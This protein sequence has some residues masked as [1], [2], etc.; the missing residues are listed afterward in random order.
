MSGSPWP[1]ARTPSII[2]GSPRAATAW[3]ASSPPPRLGS[4]PCRSFPARLIAAAALRLA[5]P[6]PSISDSPRRRDGISAR[7]TISEHFRLASSPRRHLGSY[8]HLRAM[9][10]HASS[11]RR[12]FGSH[13]HLRA[14]S[15]LAS[16][17]PRRFGSHAHPPALSPLPPSPP[18][19]LGPPAHPPAT[20]PPPP[21]P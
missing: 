8:D 3:L 16:A 1:A 6:L 17:P 15:P 10:P 14:I 19:R 12:R 11:P 9:S 7:T 21:P 4:D 20:P 18:R 5:L 13:D 2:R